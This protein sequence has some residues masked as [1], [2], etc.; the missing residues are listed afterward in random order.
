M[1]VRAAAAAAPVRGAG[2]GVA[3][4]R[5]PAPPEDIPCILCHEPA[6]CEA[7][8]CRFNRGWPD[9]FEPKVIGR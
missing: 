3:A 6:L 1:K 9:D 7:K 4:S 2:E 8:G 5:Q